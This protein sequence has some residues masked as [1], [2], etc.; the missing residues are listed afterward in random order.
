VKINYKNPL[1]LSVFILSWFGV[2]FAVM[3]RPIVYRHG[4]VKTI[5]FCGHALN[6]NILPFYK[7][8]KTQPNYE[9]Y[10]LSF[11]LSYMQKLKREGE[12]P[13]HLLWGLSLKDMIKVAKA[14]A[15]ITTHGLHFLSLYKLTSIKLIDVWHG[16]SYKG[17]D[18]K[19]F[20]PL[21]KFNGVWV[22]SKEMQKLYINKYEIDAKKV[23][24]TG[25]GRTDQLVN[26]SLNKNEILH[27]Y[28]IPKAKK[29]ILIAPTWKQDDSGRN[30]LPFGLKDEVFFKELDDLA[31]K[32]NA[33][34]I[35]RTHLNSNLD[36]KGSHLTNTSFMPYSKYEVVEDFLFI[37]DILVTDW[38]SVGID[39][40]PLRPAIFLNVPAPFK[41]GFSLGP[42]HR[43]GDVVSEFSSLKAKLEKYLVHPKDFLRIHKKDLEKSIESAYDTTLDGHSCIRYQK[44]LSKLLKH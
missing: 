13:K 30:I 4:N 34:I 39:Y 29:Y 20:A 10:Y 1:H 3:L 40:L 5:I 37:A 19:S 43:Y 35:F 17:W 26:G 21:L 14:D 15:I 12:N 7:F 16:V 11:D 28:S 38:S 33:H 41:H 6:G 8:L 22:S 25:Y 23:K 42:E 2:L 31:R 9:P 18:K 24:V 36:I 32:H 44:E 27:K